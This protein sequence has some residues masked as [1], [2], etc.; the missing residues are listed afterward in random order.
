MKLFSLIASIILGV[1]SI[2]LHGIIE[3]KLFQSGYSWTFTKIFPYI[4]CLLFASLTLISSLRFFKH[5][6]LRIVVG[7]SLFSAIIG[8][9]FG[10]NIIYQGD[11]A[12]NSVSVSSNNTQ[13]KKN[14]LT[15]IALP[16]CDFCHGSIEM[17]K[18]LKARNPNLGINFLVNS[19]DIVSLE[20]YN[21]PIDNQFDL[22]LFEDLK[23]LHHLRVHSYPTFIFTDKNGKKFLWTNDT[24]GAPA[25]DFVEKNVK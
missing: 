5:Q 14:V 25:K 18:V 4:L 21:Q 8:V 17:L 20:Q 12:N 2:L 19:S 10:L 23:E 11:F 15:V 3:Q 13:L 16:G 24:F 22:A 6:V 9:D 1:I 7:L